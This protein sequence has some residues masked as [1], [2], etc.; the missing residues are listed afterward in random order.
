MYI[1]YNKFRA[2]SVFQGKPKLLKVLN[3][4]SIFNRVENFRVTLFF[5]ASTSFSKIV[6]GEKI[7]NTVYLHLELM[8]VIWSSVVCNLDQSCD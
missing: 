3:V 8:C 7:F 1:Q 4:K 6:N 5:R 2:H